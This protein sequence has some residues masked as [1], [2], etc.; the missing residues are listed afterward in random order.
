[1]KWLFNSHMLWGAILG[2]LIVSSAV[3]LLDIARHKGPGVVHY[4]DGERGPERS[5]KVPESEYK[6]HNYVMFGLMLSL[7][8]GLWFIVARG[9]RDEA[10]KKVRLNRYPQGNDRNV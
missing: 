9:A 3:H 10:A 8:L 7:G 6:R 2:W 1:M 5:E 4:G